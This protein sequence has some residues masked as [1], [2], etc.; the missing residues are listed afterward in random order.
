MNNV[1]CYFVMKETGALSKN[2]GELMLVAA[3]YLI[4]YYVLLCPFYLK[5]LDA[6]ANIGKYTVGLVMY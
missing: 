5:P 6:L 1:G 2:S 4:G 3:Q